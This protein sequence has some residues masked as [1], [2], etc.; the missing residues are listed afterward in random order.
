MNKRQLG[1][2]ALGIAVSM[3][4]AGILAAHLLSVDQPRAA[5]ISSASASADDVS[6]ARVDG[7]SPA[8]SPSAGDD[9]GMT[10]LP[11]PTPQPATEADPGTG[12]GTS[13]DAEPR[14]TTEVLPAEPEVLALPPSQ[15]LAALVTPPFPATASSLGQVATGF[16]SDVL[17]GIPDSLIDSSSVAVQDQRMQATLAARTTL[18]SEEVLAFYRQHFAPLGLLESPITA[19]GQSETV[20]FARGDDSV[21]LAVTDVT[22]GSTYILFGTFVAEG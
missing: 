18:E 8:S 14:T 3:T 17:P 21:T 1:I 19:S 9:E 6:P 13:A 15:P 22:D 4:G 10:A 7:L 2:T 12:P 11:A 16:P 5:A 20:S